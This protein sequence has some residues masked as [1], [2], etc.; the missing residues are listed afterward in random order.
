GIRKA[1]DFL[2]ALQLTGAYKASSLANLQIRL[3]AIVVGGGLTAIDT[4]TELLAYYIAQVEKTASRV[5]ALVSERGEGVLGAMF[6]AEEREFLAEQRA[7]AAM[8]CEERARAAREVRAPNFQRLLDHWG[9]VSIVYR[10]R[11]IDSP[12]YRLNHEEV[13]KSLEEG[14]RYIENMAPLKATLDERGH[15]TAVVF[16]PQPLPHPN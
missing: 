12:A 8:V 7:H 1:S 11:V 16:E 13:I 6:D 3:P 4:A 2:M 15:V 14:V 5:E 10:K 9:G